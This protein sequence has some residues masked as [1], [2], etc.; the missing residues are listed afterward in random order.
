MR[1]KDREVTELKEI[2]SIID[3]CEIIRLGFADG[4]FP[5]IVPL[6]FGYEVEDDQLIFY[7]HGAK[8]GRKY[9]LMQK[10]ACCSFEMDHPLMLELL[11]ECKD[12]TMRYESV[13]GTAAVT[14]LEGDEKERALDL[15]MARHP[16]TRDFAYNRNAIPSTAVAKLTVL[17]VVGKRNP[18][19]GNPD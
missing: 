15:M 13:M 12:V 19:S 6:N 18:I 5:Y 4:E 1:R 2:L 9:E 3:S 7:V 16:Q 14:L 11:Y 17:T 10:N 8:A